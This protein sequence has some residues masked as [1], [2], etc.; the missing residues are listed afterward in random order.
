MSAEAPS[1][2]SS[3]STTESPHEGGVRGRGWELVLL[4]AVVVAGAIITW[5]RVPADHRDRVWA[6]DG[7]IFLAEAL[8]SSPL[9]VLFR[10]YAGY[11]HFVPRVVEVGVLPIIDLSD[12]PV[13][14][15]A[16]CAVLT[17]LAGGAVFWLT[18]DNV[19][20]LPAR[21]ALALITSV[22]PLATQETVGNL[23]DL[24]TYAMWVMPWLLLYRPRTWTTSIAWGVLAWALV[25]TEIQAIFFV[26]LILF[27]LGRAHSRQRPVFV[28]F[29]VGALAQV[30]TALVVQRT[31]S[32]GPLSVASTVMGW[33]INT[34]MPLLTADPITI[35]Q[36]VI[37][38][39]VA[40]AVIVIVPVALAAIAVLIWG[41]SSQRLLT[42]S[43]LLGS[44]AIYTG[45]AWANSGF[46]FAYAEEPLTD[47]G[48]RLAL[49]IRYGV[50]S[51]MMLAAILPIAAAVIVRRGRHRVPAQAAAWVLCLATVG[52]LGHGATMT[53][54]IRDQ[55]GRWSPAVR[56]AAAECAEQRA[57]SVH[58]LP[59][60]PDRSVDLTCAQILEF[61][62][63]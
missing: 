36:W 3:A 42:V 44:A 9:A 14:I 17:G 8:D 54:S 41:T 47:V 11:Q 53:I 57:A 31:T 38:S 56:T 21:V 7:N 55:V 13:V 16:V 49:N 2:G 28:G 10:G 45:S 59:V 4:A 33:M 18:R 32:G 24:H 1:A 29:A 62:R 26:F 46:W 51:G 58:T 40:V 20:W 50:A 61:T 63:R 48:I 15:F 19:P 37:D 30:I 5:N 6:E 43:L 12:Y 34:V 35:R 22:V 52:V 27:R 39:G 25:M 23:A 60:A